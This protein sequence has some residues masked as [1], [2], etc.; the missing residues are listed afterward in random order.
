MIVLAVG[1]IGGV[2]AL[3]FP[4]SVCDGSEADIAGIKTQEWPCS[5][6]P[7]P[8]GESFPRNLEHVS[9]R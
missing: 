9:S 7:T 1:M 6:L 3:S 8:E 5:S 4:R 2:L